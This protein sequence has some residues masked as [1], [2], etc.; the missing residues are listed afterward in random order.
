MVNRPWPWKKPSPAVPLAILISAAA[1]IR[2][3][4]VAL[5][6]PG[7]NSDEGTMGLMAMH[8][9]EGRDFPNFMYGQTY[10][11]SAESYLAAAMFWMFGPSLAALRVPMVLLFLVFLLV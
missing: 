6:W 5:E 1:V 8:I 11:G 2:F 4:L 10:M 7:S 9:A 3:A